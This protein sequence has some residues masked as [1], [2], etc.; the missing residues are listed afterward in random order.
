MLCDS[1]DVVIVPFPF[2]DSPQTKRR[3]ALV[4]SRKAFNDVHRHS[5]LAMI[6][7]GSGASWE[8]DIPITALEKTG[9]P[10]PSLIRMKLFTLDNR[11]IIKR[12]GSLHTSDQKKVRKA[13]C[14][15][16]LGGA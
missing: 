2:V 12:I 6:T 11:F 14:H 7:T 1:G 15:E 16:I 4:L 9:L 13:I 3:P 8:S 10:V 5:L